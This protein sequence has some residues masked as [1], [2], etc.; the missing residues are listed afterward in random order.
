MFYNNTVKPVYNGH[1][2]DPKIVAV[3]H[4]WPLFRGF[5]I[6]IAIKFDSARLRLATVG[7]WSL[8]RGGHKHWF[9]CTFK[10]RINCITFFVRDHSNNTR[11]FSGG[12]GWGGGRRVSK[13]PPNIKIF[14]I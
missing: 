12:V 6:K 10:L 2:W 7:R 8:F 14:G 9:D 3:V 11:H 13:V 4:R 5:S 1:P